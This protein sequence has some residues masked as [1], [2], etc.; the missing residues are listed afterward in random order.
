MNISVLRR[1]NW[2]HGYVQIFGI[3][4]ITSLLL[5]LPFLIMDGGYFFYYG[6]FNVQQIPFYLHA[7]D[8]V[9]SG[10]TGW[11][12]LTDLG[13]SFVGSYSFYL[14]GSPF[15]WL[16]IPFPSE[17]VPYLMA[18]LLMLK[19]A[20]TSVTGYAYIRRFTRREETAMFCGLMY[21]FSGFNLYNIFFNHFNEA[22]LFFPLLLI[23]MEELML[24]HCRGGFA[25]A[26][27]ACALVN[28]YFFFGE[29]LFC[30]VYF[31]LR[32][33]DYRLT[34]KKFGLLALEAVLGVLL[35]GVLL[36]P[37]F[38]AV[39]DNPRTES[40][41]TGFD[42]LFYKDVQRYGLILSSFF[43]PPDIPARPNFF[44]DSNSKWS[45]V[46][47]WLP[48]MSMTGVFAFFHGERRHWMKT[49][50]MLS[51]GICFI[52][53]LNAAF[54]L[55]N[56]SYYARWFYMPLLI[57]AAATAIALEKHRPC[58]K[59]G[60]LW[61]G[62]FI[63]AF[64]LV[65]VLPKKEGGELLWFSL[66]EY[67]DRFWVYVLIAAV[68]LICTGLLLLIA[69]NPV[70][71]RR[72]GISTL[73]ALILVTGIFMIYTGKLASGFEMEDNGK[74]TYYNQLAAEALHGRERLQLDS[75]GEFFRIDTYD[76]LDNLGMFWQLPTINAFHSVVP[77]SIMEYYKLVGGERAVASRPEPKLL[78]VRGLTSVRYAFVRENKDDV[79]MPG[80]V[81]LDTQNGYKIFENEHFVPMGFTYEYLV[82]EDQINQ[83][84]QGYKD[85]FLLKGLLLRDEDYQ[86]CSH[87]LPTLPNDQVGGRA[88]YSGEADPE[89]L[90]DEEYFEDCDLLA[91]NQVDGFAVDRRGFSASVD[92]ERENLVF[93]SVPYD[94]GWVALVNGIE[95]EIFQANGGFMAVRVP[96]GYSRIR[97]EYETPGLKLGA[98][99]SLAGLVLLILYL[100]WVRRMRKAHPE[101][102]FQPWAHRYQ[103]AYMPPVSAKDRYTS[104][105][106]RRSSQS[107]EESGSSQE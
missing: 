93:F 20:L 70:Y 9:R 17:A 27:A 65:G 25:L 90:R 47:M 76:E 48:M 52:P 31:L 101:L 60:F 75:E 87:I 26:A 83:V 14:L 51:F 96:G 80:F 53:A 74:H 6:D 61:C 79:D 50:M 5:F 34:L 105:L 30:I 72:F 100:L 64:A 22:V 57:M 63:L 69:K 81:Y 58:F 86:R 91:A 44:P 18:P 21:A 10:W 40:Y 106:L 38:W 42:T 11:D 3:G 98:I 88:I 94:Q 16:T 43:F 104:G 49:L 4:L 78:G 41:L 29:V 85:R 2:K 7:H 54:S 73:C 45:S 82:T 36:L 99:L 102:A 32:A 15:F 56:Y 92:L 62:G 19:F 39:I 37:S 33:R 23:A 95:T 68:G 1:I 28:Y 89:T 24:N 103:P 67:P 71:F 35:A 97:F 46:S 8:A 84:G 77:S 59:N 55:F 13:A 66:P 12:W 107:E